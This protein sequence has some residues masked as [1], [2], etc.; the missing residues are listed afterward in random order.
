MSAAEFFFS[1][2]LGSL[3]V[4]P[5]G[6]IVLALLGLL[7]LPFAR[8]FA[9]FAVTVSA[10]SLYAFST[11]VVADSLSG[12]L[13]MYPALPP[14]AELPEVGAIVVPGGS[15]YRLPLDYEGPNL[16]G[17]Q[18]LERLL[19]AAYLHR[20][21]GLPLLV[22]GGLPVPGTLPVAQAM[23]RS[24]KDDFGIGVRFVESRSRNTAENAARSAVLLAEAGITGIVLVTH[25]LHMPRAVEAFKRQG[26]KVVPAPLVKPDPLFGT[27]AGGFLPRASALR[28]SAAA[29]HEYL[30][31]LGYRLRF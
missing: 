21:T 10:G 7:L 12:G 23:A 9:V 20:R 18:T 30:G 29:I 28:A 11:W 26:L 4:P 15:S 31:R 25:A 16:V 14:G 5:G 17:E 19:Y 3:V 2:V 8:R 13:H 24:L 22:T 27:G 6:C 1:E